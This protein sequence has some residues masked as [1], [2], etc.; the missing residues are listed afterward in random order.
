MFRSATFKL[1][2]WY[3]ALITAIS[4]IF[5]VVIYHFATGELQ[6]GLHHQT[7]RIYRDFPVFNG[8]PLL[9]SDPDIDVGTHRI[10]IQLIYFNL[11][12]VVLG[13]IASY[14]LARRTLEPIE[15]AHARQQRFTADV[16]HELRTPLTALKMTSEVA[17]L[18]KSA[19]KDELRGALNSNLEEIAKMDALINN[20]LRLTKLDDQQTQA[21][22]TMLQSNDIITTAIEQVAPQASSKDITIKQTGNSAPLLGD[23]D[24]LVQLCVILL[25]N[26]IKYGPDKSTVTVKTAAKGEHTQISI[27]DEGQGISK[28]AL[29]HVFDRFYR[30]DGSRTKSTTDG[31]GLGLSIAKLIC[32]RHN[33]QIILTSRPGEGTTAIVEIPSKITEAG[34]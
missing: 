27:A 7:L 33:G 21:A 2:V 18:D 16:S 30:A 1:T 28:E 34:A 24:A 31:F 17:L 11:V 3:T 9:Q 8:N 4:L 12:V 22:F 5:S 10:W 29:P 14:F 25:D 13:S 32:D 19:S 20:L 23:R 15:A 26:A 6:S